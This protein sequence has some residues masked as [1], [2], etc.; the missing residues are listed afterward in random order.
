MNDQLIWCMLYINLIYH[1]AG[2]GKPLVG[3]STIVGL[4]NTIVDILK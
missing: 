4:T 3:D 2:V 1:I